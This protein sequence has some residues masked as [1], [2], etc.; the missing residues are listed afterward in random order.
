MTVAKI[1]AL[2][3]KFVSD[4]KVTSPINVSKSKI[5]RAVGSK[6]CLVTVQ[7]HLHYF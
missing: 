1:S 6:R 4:I 5:T 3:S 2:A 7:L